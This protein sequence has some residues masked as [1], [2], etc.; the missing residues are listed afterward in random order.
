[1]KVLVAYATRHGAT[2]GIAERI[3]RVLEGAGL[4]VDLTKIDDVRVTDDY[5]AF[6]I[7]SAAYYFHWLKEATRF[8]R[9]HQRDF[10]KRPVWLFSSGPVGSDKVDAEG[11]DVVKGAAPR[12]FTE[13]AQTLDARDQHV[14]FGAFDPDAEP[15]G[16]ME[17]FTRLLPAVREA[18]PT[19]DFRNWTEIES[20]A[21][22]IADEL[23]L[24]GQR[25]PAAPK[26]GREGYAP[27]S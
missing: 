22:Q 26:R 4:T 6:V 2:A 8:V 16:L 11:H 3:A 19:G 1:M 20:W 24:T 9:E 10:G 17:R 12:E 7:G 23:K 27:L 14:F 18:L 21:R 13:F 5:D 15:V 25:V